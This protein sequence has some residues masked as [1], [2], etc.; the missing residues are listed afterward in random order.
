MNQ[1]KANWQGLI[2]VVGIV[3]VVGSLA[4]VALEIR[5]NTNTARSATLQSVSEMSLTTSMAMTENAD[6]RD[7]WLAARSNS[8]TEEQDLQIRWFI[9]AMLRVQQ[10]RFN[11]IKL[12]VLELDEALEMGGRAGAYREAFFADVWE[13]AKV[14]Y[15][16]DFQ[17]FIEEHV[18]PLSA[19][20]D[21]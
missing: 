17:D 20:S 8:L 5:Q 14:Q 9:S 4:F 7:A 16:I 21:R 13:T 2:E 12:G 6:L 19:Q 10:N 1:K 18:L 15:P 11:Q 3:S